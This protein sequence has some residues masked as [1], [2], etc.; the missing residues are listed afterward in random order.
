MDR[1][2]EYLAHGSGEIEPGEHP[3]GCICTGCTLERQLE[4]DGV[5]GRYDSHACVAPHLRRVMELRQE[6]HQVPGSAGAGEY[7][8]AEVAGVAQERTVSPS[9]TVDL[10]GAA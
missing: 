5:Y 1:N 7:K 4:R 10:K 8:R 3:L 6:L 2:Q 9:P